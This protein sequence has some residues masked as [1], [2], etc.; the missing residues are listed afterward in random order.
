MLLYVGDGT[1]QMPGRAWRFAQPL[2]DEGQEA[3]LTATALLEPYGIELRDVVPEVP[4]DID[5]TAYVDA[6]F[7]SWSAVDPESGTFVYL[8]NVV[9]AS[10]PDR[11]LLAW[12]E[13]Y[14]TSGFMVA[15]YA[16]PWLHNN[17]YR[18][19][20]RAVNRASGV[21][22]P[23]LSDG[24]TIDVSFRGAQMSSRVPPRSDY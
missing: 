17:T 18:V 11:P 13:M 2:W 4:R 14:D 12:R 3:N 5:F 1:E 9:H 7:G 16:G 8:M 23:M 21:S 22:A 15:S 19:A 20:V 24:F 10:E 6:A